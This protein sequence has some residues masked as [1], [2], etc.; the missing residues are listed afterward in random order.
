MCKLIYAPPWHSDVDLV[1]PSP[2]KLSSSRSPSSLRHHHEVRSAKSGMCNF[3]PTD[4]MAR[5]HL[6][7]RVLLTVQ[8]NVKN[9]ACSLV[10]IF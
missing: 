4:R 2:Q 8:H 5:A 9:G 7:R 3:A 1:P 10:E 6:S